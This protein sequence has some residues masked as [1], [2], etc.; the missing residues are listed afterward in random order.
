VFE[1]AWKRIVETLKE[2]G[3]KSRYLD[4]LYE[5][6]ST[7][8]VNATVSD[9]YETLQ[10]EIMEE[11]GYALQRAEDKLNFA[12][13]EVELAADELDSNRDVARERTLLEAYEKKR[14]TAMRARWEFMVHREAVGMIKH[15]VLEEL[16]PIPPRRR[17]RTPT[18]A[19]A[20]PEHS[21][22]EQQ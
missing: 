6:L 10:R 7:A 19:P 16:Y 18:P 11:M 3:Y 15:D 22:E 5:R 1:P 13:L 21:T 4:R 12:L 8:A 2:R 20:Q 14:A 9:G 17:L